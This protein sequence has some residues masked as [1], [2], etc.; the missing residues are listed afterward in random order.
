MKRDDGAVRDAARVAAALE[1]DPD[2]STI[3]V[4]I[5]MK[6]HGK[7]EVLR[8][9][10]NA[11]PYDRIVIDVTG[12]ARPAD[13]NLVV[14]T[15][16]ITTQLPA[17]A[18]GQ[19]RVTAWVRLDPRRDNYIKDQDDA[20]G[21]GLYPRHRNTCIWVDEYAQMATPNLGKDNANL[22]LAL[23]SSRHYHVTLLLAFPR[24]TFVPV[25]TLAQADRVFIFKTPDIT[26]RERI[27]TN[28]GFP[29]R[30]FEARYA[31]TMA[32][33]KHA[34]LLWDSQQGVLIS[35][36]PIPLKETHGPRS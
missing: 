28:I 26:D 16:P 32:R 7:S 17:P 22:K 14:I 36:P 19:H 18:E 20:L 8:E 23:Q 2:R 31:E 34:F 3:A 27:A 30:E 21:L 5:G 29:K 9:I 15:A 4:A 25:L 10:F 6:G 12:D 1:L 24:P 33:D 35:C 13:P 11:W